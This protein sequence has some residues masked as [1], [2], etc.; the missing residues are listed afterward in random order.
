MGLH[1][2]EYTVA[3]LGGIIVS[4]AGLG[5][6][7]VLNQPQMG[8]ALFSMGAVATVFAG[9]QE[10]Q[11]KAAS[12]ADKVEHGRPVTLVDSFADTAPR[13]QKP[14]SPPKKAE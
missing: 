1:K 4:S 3:K 6:W 7:K 9:W 12:V 13:T 8:G 10:V 5:L 2:D 14:D 11:M